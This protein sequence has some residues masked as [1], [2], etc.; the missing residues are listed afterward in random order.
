MR[1]TKDTPNLVAGTGVAALDF[2]DPVDGVNRVAN[3]LTD[4]NEANGEADVLIAEYHEGGP[5]SS[6]T[7]TLADQLK[8]PVF[9]H[10]VN[11]TSPKVAA[12]LQGHTHQAY[13]YDVQIPGEAA[14]STRP[15]LQT[16]Q[17][18][19]AV[20]KVQLG[21]D[22]GD[23]EGHRLQ[24]GQHPG[25]RAVAR[26][27]SRTRPTRPPSRSST[28]PSRIAAPIANQPVGKITASITRGRRR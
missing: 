9:A 6:T 20:G 16:G 26:A 25:H 28:T 5:F 23:Q 17:Y 12:V 18:A 27:A 13:V 19:A 4:G 1:V 14:G 3:Q 15:V 10:L 8:V 22:A 2:I 24:R 21:Y 7:G 11:D